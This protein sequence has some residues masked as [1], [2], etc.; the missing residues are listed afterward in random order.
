MNYVSKFDSGELD[1]LTMDLID[2]PEYRNSNQSEQEQLKKDNIELINS[3]ID[4]YV[5]NKEGVTSNLMKRVTNS[6]FVLLGN[7]GDS[8]SYIN[9]TKQMNEIL[10]NIKLNGFIIDYNC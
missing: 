2:S 8:P 7:I 10:K 4:F 1:I 5:N 6:D 3:N 9:V